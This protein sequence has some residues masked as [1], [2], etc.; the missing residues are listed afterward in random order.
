MDKLNIV[1]QTMRDAVW[2]VPTLVLLLGTG[3]YFTIRLRGLQFRKFP[4]A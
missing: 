4:L 2:G 1:L 3:L